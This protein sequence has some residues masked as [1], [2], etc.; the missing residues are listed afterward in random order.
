[1]DQNKKYTDQGLINIIKRLYFFFHLTKFRPLA[2]KSGKNSFVFWRI[3]ISFR[4]FLTFIRISHFCIT[5]RVEI[6][7]DGG[8]GGQGK[9]C[10]L[11]FIFNFHFML[12]ERPTYTFTRY[13]FFI[14]YPFMASM[15]PHAKP[16]KTIRMH[17]RRDFNLLYVMLP[18][19]RIP[20]S[21]LGCE[22]IF[23]FI[24]KSLSKSATTIQI[25]YKTKSFSYL[26]SLL[27]L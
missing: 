11:L 2:Q 22:K 13:F 27:I 9:E 18:N 19:I 17:F 3:S 7:S 21:F 8:R 14:F 26:S 1:M 23:Y 16:P 20:I 12:I 10:K 5:Q 24:R 25:K 15:F 4:H 6:N